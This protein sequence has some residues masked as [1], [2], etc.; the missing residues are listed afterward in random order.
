MEI[1][2][3]TGMALG[4]SIRIMEA[5]HSFHGGFESSGPYVGNFLTA[6]FGTKECACWNMAIR[7]HADLAY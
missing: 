4:H 2:R 5:V 3:P 1:D 7:H 6:F